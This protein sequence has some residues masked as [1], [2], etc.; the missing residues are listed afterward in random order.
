MIAARCI[1]ECRSRA[2]LRVWQSGNIG[3]H[4]GRFSLLAY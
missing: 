4:F 2:V 1:F 3:T